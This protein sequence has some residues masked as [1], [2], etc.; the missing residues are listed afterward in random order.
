MLKLK[1][2]GFWGLPQLVALPQWLQETANS[3]QTLFIKN[4]DNLE[5][6][7]K[8]LSTLINLK[9]HLISDCPKL[10]SLPDNIHHLTHLKG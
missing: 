7:P 2:V 3:L 10:I 4:C 5:M 9:S 6:L 1:C 8:W